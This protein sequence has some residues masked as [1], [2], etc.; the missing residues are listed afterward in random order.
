MEKWDKYF[1][2]ENPENDEV[3]DETQVNIE[4]SDNTQKINDIDVN[5]NRLDLSVRDYKEFCDR[6][7]GLNEAEEAKSSITYQSYTINSDTNKPDKASETIYGLHNAIAQVSFDE[8]HPEL[9]VVSI[10]FKSFDDPE[11]R[12]FW[13]RIQKWRNMQSKPLEEDVIPIFV[14]NLVENESTNCLREKESYT[15]L[16][17]NIVNP[18]LCYITREV[19]TM[20][21][22][23]IKN[24][25]DEVVGGNVIK[26]LVATDFLTFELRDDI[27]INTIKAEELREIEESRFLDEETYGSSN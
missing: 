1:N 6:L 3:I 21:A 24:E 12:M 20:V 19:P 23:N 22:E 5:D 2:Q 14:V 26:M 9:A 10:R 27:D 17:A 11:L 4:T 25:R 18:L 16:S 7:S 13:A 15:I 8:L